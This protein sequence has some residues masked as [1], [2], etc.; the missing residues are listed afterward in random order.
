[1]AS[2][3]GSYLSKRGEVKA[4]DVDRKKILAQV[5]E[6]TR[7][8]AHINS[9]VSLGEWSERE[10]RTL[11]RMK[12]EEMMLVAHGAQDWLSALKQE[13]IYLRSG[14][15]GVSPLPKMMTLCKLYFPE[16]VGAALAYKTACDE[17][18][19][20]YL[21]VSGEID[22]EKSKALAHGELAVAKAQ[23]AVVDRRGDALLRASTDSY[24]RLMLLDREATKLMS[25]IVSVPSAVTG[26][27]T[28]SQ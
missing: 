16:L 15:G 13:M 17:C 3:V 19:V 20:R 22:F 10:R 1:V 18:H 9:V 14:E 2:F 21:Q 4:A 27:D 6:N 24:E 26:S 7:V 25:G 12:L 8:T 11:R 5:S 28:G 23:T